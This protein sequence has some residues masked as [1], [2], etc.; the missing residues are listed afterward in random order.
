MNL[1]QVGYNIYLCDTPSWRNANGK[2][3]T[4]NTQHSYHPTQEQANNPELV[5]MFRLETLIRYRMA[6]EQQTKKK[7][8]ILM[9]RKCW[10]G[11]IDMTNCLVPD[12]SNPN[13]VP[14]IYNSVRGILVE[15]ED[16]VS[17]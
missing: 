14:R 2:V 10:D 17:L 15:F 8:V 5:R 11:K 6:L 3:Y 7:Y 13:W 9:F 4:M 1:E 12:P 16:F